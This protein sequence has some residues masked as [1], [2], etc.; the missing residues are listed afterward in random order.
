MY[1]ASRVFAAEAVADPRADARPAGELRA[2]LHERDRGVVVDRFGVERVDHAEIVGD[3]A[4]VRQ[5]FAEPEPAFAV[6]LE[7]EHR[8]G[9]GELG[10]IGRHAREA[11]THADRVGQILAAFF[12]HRRLGIKE[13]HL[14]RRAGLKEIDHS[15]GFGRMIRKAGEAADLR[16]AGV[17][18]CARLLPWRS[19]PSDA[20]PSVVEA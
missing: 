19:I 18:S 8:R 13:I 6:L 14:R 11:L 15:L 16:G 20:A 4:Q 17:L 3:L 5:Q 2:G 12:F 1:P 9:D 7:L 10:L